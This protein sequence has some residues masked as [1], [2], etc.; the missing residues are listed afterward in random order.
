MAKHRISTCILALILGAC[1]EP[2]ADEPTEPVEDRVA[3]IA[4]EFVDGYYSHY[5]EDVYEVGYAD[6]PMDRFG[7][8]S[9]ESDTAW[10]TQ[11][12]HWLAELNGID[13]GAISDTPTALTYVFTRAQ[14]QAL[15]DR[16]VCQQDLWNI[17]PTWTGWQFMVASTL[18]IQPVDT[19]EQRADALA[20][21]VDTARFV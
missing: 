4:S 11:V 18:A 3:R 10:D 17:S 7:D 15:V 20:R 19:A 21:A 8:H 13:P 16:R 2:P 1:A 5:P 14:M 9:E 6:G 12:D